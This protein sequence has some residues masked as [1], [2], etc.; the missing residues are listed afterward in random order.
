MNI[1]QYLDEFEPC[2]MESYH[3]CQERPALSTRSSQVTLSSPLLDCEPEFTIFPQQAVD[4]GPSIYADPVEALTPSPV[5]ATR[6]RGPARSLLLA[7]KKAV[8]NPYY[9]PMARSSSS[10]PTLATLNDCALSKRRKLTVGLVDLLL[11]SE[12]VSAPVSRLGSQS[13]CNMQTSF[14]S[15]ESFLSLC[16]RLDDE[17]LAISSS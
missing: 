2:Y 15:I 4:I 1:E 9:K 13:D 17:N 8:G 12:S 7:K 5:V 6:P 3:L 11:R 14:S 10:I 16:T